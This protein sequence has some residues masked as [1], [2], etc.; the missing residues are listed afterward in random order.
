MNPFYS[1][2]IKDINTKVDQILNILIDNG[3]KKPAPKKPKNT[4]K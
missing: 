2:Q 4:E 1:K 3:K